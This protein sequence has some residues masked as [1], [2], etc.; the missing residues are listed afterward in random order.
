MATYKGI[1]GFTWQKL[2]SDP[3]ASSDTDGTVWYNSTS[4]KFKIVAQGAGAW[5]SGGNINTA[6]YNVCGSG[7]SN[8][9]ALIFAGYN[10]KP[11]A[12]YYA[13]TESYNVD[14]S[15]DATLADNAT[16][17][18]NYSAPGA[19][20]YKIST[21]LIKESVTAPH[22][23]YSNYILLMEINDGIVT[24]EDSEKF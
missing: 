21:A 14:N 3:T 23:T 16:G 19:H 10:N 20:R 8:T 5:S 6:R 1:Q 9:A 7:A 24:V 2:S 18:P 13:V 15:T 4:G 11:S 17:T 12:V 22:T